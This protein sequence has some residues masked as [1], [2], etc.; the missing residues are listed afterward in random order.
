M[1][2]S[3]PSDEE[4]LRAWKAG[5]LRVSVS[6]NIDIEAIL[7]RQRDRERW[8]FFRTFRLSV[9]AEQDIRAL[10]AAYRSL[11]EQAEA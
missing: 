7:E 8:P 6:E 5:E 1:S 11:K 9:E 2:V 4:I 3:E 10:A